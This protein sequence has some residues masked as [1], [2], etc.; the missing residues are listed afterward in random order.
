MTFMNN[1]FSNLLE[2]CIVIYF[3]DILIYSDDISVHHKYIKEVLKH[4]FLQD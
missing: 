4:L 3:N 2:I 1:I